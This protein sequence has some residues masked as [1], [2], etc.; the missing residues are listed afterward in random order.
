MR[1]GRPTV[2][3]VDDDASVRKSLQRLLRSAG[4]AV[5]T[6]ASGVEFMAHAPFVGSYC[7]VLDVQMPHMNGLE[8]QHR[9]A[10]SGSTLPVIFITAHADSQVRDRTMQAGATAFL[11]KPF[12]DHALFNAI[13]ES[14]TSTE[15]G[16]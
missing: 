12:N 4:F 5:Q 1:N 16:V 6:F 15:P 9:L 3:V 2:L 8:V 13:E 14:L 11:V 10:E 7:L